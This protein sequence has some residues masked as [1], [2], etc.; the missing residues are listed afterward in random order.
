[1]EK[2]K[3]VLS[4][5]LKELISKKHTG[6]ESK[7]EPIRPISSNNPVR[8][9]ATKKNGNIKFVFFNSGTTRTATQTSEGLKLNDLENKDVVVQVSDGIATKEHKKKICPD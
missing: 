1:M 7:R 4:N 5:G 9:I 6:I 8:D 3:E 2:L